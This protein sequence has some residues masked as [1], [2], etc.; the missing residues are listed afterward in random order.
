MPDTVNILLT[1]VPVSA[2]FDWAVEQGFD[3]AF[4]NSTWRFS[5]LIGST[6][7][8]FKL[9]TRLRPAQTIC[10]ASRGKNFLTADRH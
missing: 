5:E 2:G 3:H 10:Q 9:Y 8:Y 6:Q 1:H 7:S 4:A